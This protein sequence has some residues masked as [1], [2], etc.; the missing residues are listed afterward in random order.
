[1]VLYVHDNFVIVVLY[2]DDMLLIRNT[3]EMIKYVKS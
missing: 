3:R 2:V 1:M